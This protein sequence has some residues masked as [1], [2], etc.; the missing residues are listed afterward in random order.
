MLLVDAGPLVAAV[1]VNDQH[2]RACVELLTRQTTPVVAPV[3]VLSEVAYLLETR[4]GQYAVEGLVRS[5]RG[6]ELQIEPVAPSDW[7]RIEEL[8][9]GYEDLELGLVDASIIAACE[10]LGETRLAT[11]DHRHFGAVQP[12]HCKALELLP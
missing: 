1:I 3:L 9:S 7:G 10:R 6:G 11:L 5:I 8:I 2:H 4:V 12:R